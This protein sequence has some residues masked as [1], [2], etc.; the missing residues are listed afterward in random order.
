MNNVYVMSINK[1]SEC[2]NV[3]IGREEEVAAVIPNELGQIAYQVIQAIYHPVKRRIT[4]A[5]ICLTEDEHE[6]L[7]PMVGNE[8][9]V[10]VKDGTI[11][12]KFT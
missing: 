11:T 6:R 4:R 10:E 3:E 2:V 1:T 8:V 12:F 7:R 9:T 5:I